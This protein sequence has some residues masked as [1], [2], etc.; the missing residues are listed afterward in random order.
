LGLRRIIGAAVLALAVGVGVFAPVASANSATIAVSCTSV[1]FNYVDFFVGTG[2][3]S[4]ETWQID[5]GPVNTKQFSFPAPNMTAQ[6]VVPINPGPGTHTITATVSG[7]WPPGNGSPGGSFTP[8]T[9]SMSV[10]CGAP[11]P[12][13]VCTYT[14]GFYRNHSDVTSNVLGSGTIPVGNANLDAAQVQAILD[15]TPG[16]PGG[17]T[18]TSNVL[19][20]LAQQVIT[21]ELN[22][23]RGSGPVPTAD[24]A[25]AN[26]AFTVTGGTALASSLSDSQI[27]DLIT[28]LDAFNSSA[29]CH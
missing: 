21:A 6:D 9:V 26:A 13:G 11:P 29:D 4:T 22:A 12:S 23:L 18:T 3:F 5:S 15:A 24:I 19:L 27:G 28:P 16:K 7:G 25:A 20:N 14:K 1:T 2:G 10:D 8:V 17:I